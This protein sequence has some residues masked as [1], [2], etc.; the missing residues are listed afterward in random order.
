MRSRPNLWGGLLLMS[1]TYRNRLLGRL[2]PEDLAR[3]EAAMTPVILPQR[4]QLIPPNQ[5]ITTCYFLDTG[6]A[7][8]TLA[9]AD[10][11]QAEIG[12]IGSEGMIDAAVAMGATHSPLEV[13]MQLPGT[14]HAVPSA[15]VVMLSQESAHFR[16]VLLAFANS[17]VIQISQSLLAALTLTVEGRLSRWLLMSCD[18]SASD[19]IPMTHEFLSL[20]LGA[21]RAG[22]TDALNRLKAAGLIKTSRGAI[23]IVDRG[24]LGARAGDSYA[25]QRRNVAAQS[26]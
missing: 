15:D 1:S 8:V 14:G 13:F 17:F 20:M 7:S 11:R 25:V 4:Y 6:V 18:R 3:L 16:G 26:A 5:P 24:G 22:V 21:R 10:G 2:R 9:T 12:V 19:S 23:A